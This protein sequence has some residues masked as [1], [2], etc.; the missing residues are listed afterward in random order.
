[1]YYLSVEHLNRPAY[2]ACM[3]VFMYEYIHIYYYDIYV[4]IIVTKTP[5]ITTQALLHY[6]RAGVSKRFLMITSNMNVTNCNADT[7]L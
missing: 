1:M 2:S 4:Y 5:V 3:R 7:K 6:C